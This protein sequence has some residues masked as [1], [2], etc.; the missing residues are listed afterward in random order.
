MI[1][2]NYSQFIL[3]YPQFVNYSQNQTTNIYYNNALILGS[4]ILSLFTS[5]EP[6]NT[7]DASTNTPTLVN[8]TGNQ[9]DILLCIKNGSVNFGNGSIT[10][11][12]NDIVQYSNGTWNNIGYPTQYYWS[13]IILAHI[14]TLMTT[15]QVGRV[16]SA[17]EDPVS[18]VLS[19]SNSS[20]AEWWNQTMYG[21]E[22]WQL[23]KQR[24]GATYFSQDTYNGY[25]VSGFLPY[26][27]M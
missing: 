27:M 25:P 16:S 14:L 21:A 15:R 26:G 5:P 3:D 10:F 9:G 2:F 7:W 6:I 1:A 8:G 18:G 12:V 17:N 13:C 11:V 23:V 20:S 19:Y 4:K 24:G 22:C